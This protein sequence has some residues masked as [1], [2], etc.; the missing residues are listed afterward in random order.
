MNKLPLLRIMA[1]LSAA[2]IGCLAA[3]ASSA[4]ASPRVTEYKLPGR[5][6]AP[7]RPHDRA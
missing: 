6:R 5:V 3:V 4:A 7:E 2:L 1:A